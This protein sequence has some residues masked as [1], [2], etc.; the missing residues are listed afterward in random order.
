M[1]F[2]SEACNILGKKPSYY[3]ANKL[4][5]HALGAY[6]FPDDGTFESKIYEVIQYG[7]MRVRGYLTGVSYARVGAIKVLTWMMMDAV[8]REANGQKFTEDKAKSSGALRRPLH[9]PVGL[10]ESAIIAAY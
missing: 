10:I 6:H 7:E 3:G 2:R 8:I 9:L 5:L 4:E 1:L